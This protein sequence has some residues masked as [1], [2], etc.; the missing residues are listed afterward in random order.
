MTIDDAVPTAADLFGEDLAG[1]PPTPPDRPRPWFLGDA[2][3]P[4]EE[5][6]DEAGRIAMAAEA[7]QLPFLRV[8]Q[9]LLEFVGDGCRTTKLGTLYAV[10]RR[11]VEESCRDGSDGWAWHPCGT[12]SR[13]QQ[14]WDLLTRH[15]WLVREDAGVRPTGTPLVGT[16]SDA[17]A[18]DGP[19]EDGLDGAR[20]LLVAVLES[21]RPAFREFSTMERA[22][23]DI[24][25]AL[26]VASGPDGLVLPDHPCD[27]RLLHCVESVDFLVGLVRHPYVRDVPLDRSSGHVADSALRGLALTARTLEQLITCG[28]VTDGGDEEEH[29]YEADA[30][31]RRPVRTYRA[32]ALMRGAV[33]RV[34]GSRGL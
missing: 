3:A 34:R 31:G 1:A 24:W 33:A 8:A 25:D 28:V 13:V 30:P 20:R 5:P 17:R 22:E 19:D 27:G 9:H 32:P 21:A 26:L 6:S 12:D 29:W 2:P 23:D 18:E 4:R 7:A 14:A 10:D 16:G 15:G 11:R